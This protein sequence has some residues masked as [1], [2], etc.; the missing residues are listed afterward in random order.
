MTRLLAC[1]WATRPTHSR[2]GR[3]LVDKW[4]PIVYGYCPQEPDCASCAGTHYKPNILLNVG[5]AQDSLPCPYCDPERY[6]KEVD[7]IKK[8]SPTV[9]P[10]DP[11]P[12]PPDED[13]E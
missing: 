2:N 8:A 13:D 3:I 11:K 10:A 7:R 9:Y 12:P 4:K 1:P 6:R 5:R